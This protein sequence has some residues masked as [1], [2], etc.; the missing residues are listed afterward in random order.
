MTQ[1]LARK[2]RPRIFAEL[3]GQEHVVR[4]L[5]NAGAGGKTRFS[6]R[7]DS[8][9][10]EAMLSS[11]RGEVSTVSGSNREW[12]GRSGRTVPVFIKWKHKERALVKA[13]PRRQVPLARRAPKTYNVLT[14][15][16]PALQGSEPGQVRKEAAKAIFCKCRG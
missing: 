1:V 7:T 12:R 9:V 15:G 6:W 2:W 16:L 3:V 10:F 8:I 11:G 14:A 13:Q 5:E 4:A